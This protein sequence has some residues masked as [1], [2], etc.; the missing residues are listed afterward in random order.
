MIIQQNSMKNLRGHFSR[1]LLNIGLNGVRGITHQSAG[2][3]TVQE[4]REKIS[5]VST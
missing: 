5:Y 2:Y 4:S 3:P 1:K